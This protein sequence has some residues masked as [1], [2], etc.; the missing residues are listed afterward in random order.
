MKILKSGSNF[1]FF[2][3]AGIGLCAYLKVMS[4]VFPRKY[5]YAF[6]SLIDYYKAPFGQKLV[7]REAA[8]AYKLDNDQEA[9]VTTKPGPIFKAFWFL[10][11]G[12]PLELLHV[13]LGLM[14]IL[15]FFWAI[16]PIPNGVR[17]LSDL[18]YGLSGYALMPVP[19][20]LA[21]DITNAGI[22]ADLATEKQNYLKQK[23]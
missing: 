3:G 14:N 5:R 18:G 8:Y 7:P 1:W 16:I 2:L 9:W 10:Y 6:K 15:C 20:V 4:L 21:D 13:S 11:I 12:I 19:A 22:Q 17:L 23:I